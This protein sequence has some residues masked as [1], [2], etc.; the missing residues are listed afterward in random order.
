MRQPRI[1]EI[2]GTIHRE[3]G[4]TPAGGQWFSLP[5]LRGECK[6]LID[7]KPPQAAIEGRFSSGGGI[8]H[9]PLVNLCHSGTRGKLLRKSWKLFL[10]AV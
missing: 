8:S 9:R 7:G 5:L 6:R 4:R 2:K 1:L 10:I 3:K